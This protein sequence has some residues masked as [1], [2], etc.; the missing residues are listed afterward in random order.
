M[1]RGRRRGEDV[2]FNVFIREVLPSA[3]WGFVFIAFGY[4]GLAVRRPSVHL[5]C[6]SLS[7]SYI[8]ASF[9][10][11]RCLA[12]TICSHLFVIFFL[13]HI[14]LFLAG[15]QKQGHRSTLPA[16]Y[17]DFFKKKKCRFQHHN[18]VEINAMV[19]LKSTFD[20]FSTKHFPLGVWSTSNLVVTK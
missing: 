6:L 9:V 13:N 16:K 15:E 7:A 5:S 3:E 1:G 10:P 17:T 12:W 2:N 11:F 20:I 4:S 14:S 8:R 18:C 19:V